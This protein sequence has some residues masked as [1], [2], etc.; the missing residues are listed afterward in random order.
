MRNSRAN[1]A[2]TP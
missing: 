2:G 1:I